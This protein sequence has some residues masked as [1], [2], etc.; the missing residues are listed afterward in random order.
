MLEHLSRICRILSA[1]GGHALLVG[2][3][4]SG[5]QSL[6]RLATAMA[7]YQLFQP[8]ISKN[9]GKTEWRDD[10]K[11]KNYTGKT[12]E[13]VAGREEAKER[14][15]GGWFVVGS[16]CWSLTRLAM[17]QLFQL[18]ISKSY[19]KTDWRDDLKVK[20]NGKDER[21]KGRCC[22]WVFCGRQWLPVVDPSGHGRGHEPAVAARDL[23]ELRQ[24][25]VERRPQG[26]TG[27]TRG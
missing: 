9:Y 19:S 20:Q 23:Q 17:Y 21:G 18:Q 24:D 22:R 11:V 2:V 1:P 16:G 4:G 13:G 26:K 6:T 14:D 5:R 12:R 25:G 15:T 10:L 8:E 3:G 27:K 7:T